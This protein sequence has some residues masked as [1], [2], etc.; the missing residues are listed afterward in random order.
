MEGPISGERFIICENN[1]GFKEV[2]EMMAGQLNRRKAGIH[3]SPIL[4]AL[5]W[6]WQALSRLWGRQ[7]TITRETAENAQ[8]ISKFDNRKLLNA[9]PLFQYTPVQQTIARMAAMFLKEYNAQG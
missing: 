1:Y 3:A 8:T 7:A 4:T 6:R 2:L 5:I 9:L